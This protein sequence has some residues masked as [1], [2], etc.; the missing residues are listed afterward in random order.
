MPQLI[1]NDELW[2]PADTE[3]V[4]NTKHV[5]R[6]H[7]KYRTGATGT[8]V[9]T[10]QNAREALDNSAHVVVSNAN[11]G[12]SLNRVNN[13][14]G[15]PS[16]TGGN[17]VQVAANRA[18]VDLFPEDTSAVEDLE[19]EVIVENA[20]QAGTLFA[21]GGQIP[22]TNYTAEAS[23]SPYVDGMWLAEASKMTGTKFF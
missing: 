12:A 2:N 1:E 19:M 15:V 8:P 4:R 9:Q 10:D 16:Y 14:Y 6:A 13:S 5:S 18:G 3:L 11:L 20:L 7:T 17:V 22:P 21:K 23:A